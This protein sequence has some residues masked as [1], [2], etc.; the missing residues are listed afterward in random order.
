VRLVQYWLYAI[1]VLD[2]G[3]VD[4]YRQQIAFCIDDELS[5]ASVDLFAALTRGRTV[6]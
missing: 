1:P 4:R 6:G 3:G 5:F 2:V